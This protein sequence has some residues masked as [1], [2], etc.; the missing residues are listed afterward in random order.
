MA[1]SLYIPD[2][3]AL[4]LP[5]FNEEARIVQTLTYYS[6]LS[7]KIYIIDNHSTDKTLELASNFDVEVI[8][9]ANSGTIESPEWTLWLLNKLQYQYFLFLSCSE[10]ISHDALYSI[11]SLVKRK[12]ELCY[13]RRISYT[14]KNKSLIF[15]PLIDLLPFQEKGK[16]P[17][18]FASGRVL[19]DYY[20]NIKIHDNFHCFRHYC[21]FIED[22]NKGNC[23]K[24]YRPSTDFNVLK[25]L[26]YYA[27]AES[28]EA[29]LSP[30]TNNLTANFYLIRCVREL[31]YLVVLFLSFRLTQVRANELFARIILHLQ[32]Y[33]LITRKNIG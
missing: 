27:K 28:N 16:Y 9:H 30:T 32:I 8:T 7:K 19:R 14:H 23:I 5:A 17:C 22:P 1:K 2:D 4:I 33:I 20:L 6:F 26:L 31:F 3:C 18:R 15:D 10:E 24:H 13:W 12:I 29:L 25:K 21:S 11:K